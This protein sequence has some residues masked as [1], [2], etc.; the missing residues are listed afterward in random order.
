MIDEIELT[1]T[2]TQYSV[3]FTSYTGTDH[4]IGFRMNVPGSYYSQFIDDVKWEVAPTCPD[5]TDIVIS[6]NTTS[7]AI[8]SWSPGGS[9]TSWQVGYAASSVTDPS[10]ITTTVPATNPTVELSGLPDSS[11]FN[12]WVRSVCPGNDFGAWI[13]PYSFSTL[14]TPTGLPYV[15]D[16]ESAV[17]PALP[18][19]GSQ[20]N[21][22]SGNEWYVDENPGDGFNSNTLTYRYDTDNAADVWFFTRGLNLIA[23]NSYTISYRYGNDSDF[24]HESLKVM[25]GMAPSPGSMSLEIADYPTIQ[26][27]DGENDSMTEESITFEVP[28]TGVYYFGFNAYSVAD[29]NH[30]YV[31]DIM[32]DFGLS[33]SIPTVAGVG[34]YPNPVKNVLNLTYA[35][36][37]S[38]VA[39]YNLLGQK[40]LENTVNANTAKVDMSG[41][42]AGSYVVKVTADNQT[43][44]IKVIKE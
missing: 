38:N 37:I 8:V 36:S 5:V 23:G 3:D 14:C 10:G 42:S 33:T 7:S 30:L 9:E 20:I 44:S 32:V 27:P 13:G 34:Y 24:Y 16:F 43:K 26:I 19:C 28:E 12:V 25:G 17:A 35:Q 41:L 39:V 29:Q 18:G 15:E 31:D 6:D 21:V 1:D 4:Y 2:P 11:A 40:V 22:G